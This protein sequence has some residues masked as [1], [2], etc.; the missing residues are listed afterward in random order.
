MMRLLRL[1]NRSR[2]YI[3]K[4]KGSPNSAME[5]RERNDNLRVMR[6]RYPPGSVMFVAA[7][8]GIPEWTLYRMIRNKIVEY[9]INDEGLLCLNDHA[10]EKIKKLTQHQTSRKKIFEFARERGKSSEAIKKWLQRHR[11]L[12]Q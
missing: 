2:G 4:K 1:A 11:N 12:S 9:T 7:E 6:S 8:T 10:I 5:P 3:K